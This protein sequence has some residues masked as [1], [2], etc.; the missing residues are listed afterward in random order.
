MKKNKNKKSKPATFKCFRCSAPV[1][2]PECSEHIQFCACALC[3]TRFFDKSDLSTSYVYRWF[4]P[5]LD[6][7]GC[8]R[9]YTSDRDLHSTK[10]SEGR[11]VFTVYLNYP[12]EKVPFFH[13]Y[14]PLNQTYHNQWVESLPDLPA[15]ERAKAPPLEYPTTAH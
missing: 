15:S 9:L 8:A 13:L 4:K 10:D 11:P 12:G 7:D 2:L 1:E 3:S 6:R 14:H 5:I